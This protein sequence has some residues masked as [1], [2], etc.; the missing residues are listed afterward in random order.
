MGGSALTMASTTFAAIDVL[1]LAQ[2]R[3][4]SV[5]GSGCGLTGIYSIASTASVAVGTSAG[6][7]T[8][9]EAP[10]VTGTGSDVTSCSLDIVDF[11]LLGSGNPMLA[12]TGF[13]AANNEYKLAGVANDATTLTLND[14][15]TLTDV[16]ADLLSNRNDLVVSIQDAD[17][18]TAGDCTI[19][20]QGAMFRVGYASPSSTDPSTIFLKD[21]VAM[22]STSADAKCSVQLV[23]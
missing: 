22:D 13:T 5:T 11:A 3:L 10:A 6:V 4:V 17:S 9:N 21:A 14:P 12:A 15:S 18:V 23:S 1:A 20:T 8:V 16:D 19:K 7:I 2:N